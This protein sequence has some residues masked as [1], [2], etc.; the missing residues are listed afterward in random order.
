MTT[1]SEYAAAFRKASYDLYDAHEYPASEQMDR[2]AEVFQ[3]IAEKEK[4]DGN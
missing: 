3:S 1:P 4:R 2:I